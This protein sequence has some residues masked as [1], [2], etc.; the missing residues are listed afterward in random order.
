[1]FITLDNM[2]NQEKYEIVKKVLKEFTF[3][4]RTVDILKQVYTYYISDFNQLIGANCKSRA[5]LNFED[6]KQ[7]IRRKI[8]SD[9]NNYW[10]LKDSEIKIVEEIF[11]KDEEAIL[12][13]DYIDKLFISDLNTQIKEME[14][15]KKEE[16][17]KEDER[18]N[19]ILYPKSDILLEPVKIILQNNREFPYKSD[20]IKSLLLIELNTE[21]IFAILSGYEKW[22]SPRGYIE[23]FRQERLNQIKEKKLKVYSLEDSIFIIKSKK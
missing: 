1:M 16:S 9:R 10:H 19:K 8:L 18:L 15:I 14:A 4:L 5:N 21:Q 3:Q 11:Q 17:N 2:E 7:Q 13:K 20:K 23:K 22:S 12:F 6:L